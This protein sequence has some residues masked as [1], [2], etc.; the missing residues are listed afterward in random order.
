[1]VQGLGFRGFCGLGGV[2]PQ[3]G[4]EVLAIRKRVSSWVTRRVRLQSLSLRC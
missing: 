1:M 3:K 4:F 2:G